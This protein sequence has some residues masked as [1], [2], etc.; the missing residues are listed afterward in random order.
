M[1][2][3]RD[4]TGMM[5]KGIISKWPNISAIFRCVND[6]SARCIAIHSL[7]VCIY[8]YICEYMG[9][10]TDEDLGFNW[11]FWWFE[12]VII[13]MFSIVLGVAFG[14]RPLVSFSAAVI[15]ESCK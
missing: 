2:S 13:M 12:L 10:G 7:T 8:I 5:V 1:T 9:T 15:R 4:V 11:F 14:F 3:L 6:N